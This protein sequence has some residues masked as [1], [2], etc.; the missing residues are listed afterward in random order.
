MSTNRS[1][2]FQTN[3]GLEID[4]DVEAV[5]IYT[6]DWST[7]LDTGDTIATVVYTAAARINDPTPIVVV[8]SGITDSNSDTYVK[9]SG[10][11]VNKTYVVTAK[12][13]TGNAVTD[14]RN[15]RVKCVARA[16]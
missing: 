16:A 5:M 3:T 2:F 14:R 8:D 15:F 6:F 13:V 9:L 11:Q 1:G 4:K 10:G 12:V 7:W